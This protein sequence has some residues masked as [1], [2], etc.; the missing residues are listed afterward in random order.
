MHVC[1]VCMYVSD[2]YGYS[3]VIS[4]LRDS[5]SKSKVEVSCR[6]HPKLTSDLHIHTHKEIHTKI[7]PNR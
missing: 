3:L 1:N 7:N 6:R 4:R 2:R 5:V